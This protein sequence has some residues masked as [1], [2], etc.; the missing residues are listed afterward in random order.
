MYN[1]MKKCHKCKIDKELSSFN[2]NKRRE[3]G[4]QSICKPC[5][6]EEDARLY[7][8]NPSKTKERNKRYLDKNK[9][10][11]S[12]YRDT[13]KCLICSESR[14]WVLDFHHL[15]QNNKDYNIADMIHNG[16]S[17]NNI[18]KEMEKCICVCSNCH[19]NIHHQQKVS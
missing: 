11:W 14:Y 2:K 17:I 7:K 10:W 18:L 6:K 3:D 16:H 5:K 15:E 9:K 13:L 19:R 12:E 8:A 4:L 1:K